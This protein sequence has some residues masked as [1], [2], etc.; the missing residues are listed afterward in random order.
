MLPGLWQRNTWPASVAISAK[1]K[2]SSPS[3]F[4]TCRRPQ[5][6]IYRSFFHSRICTCINCTLLFCLQ[7]V[8]GLCIVWVMGAWNNGITQCC[9]R[10]LYYDELH[11]NCVVNATELEYWHKFDYKPTELPVLGY[12]NMQ[13]L[14]HKII[15]SLFFIGVMYDIVV[16]QFFLE[17]CYLKCS[18]INV[19]HTSV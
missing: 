7:H 6:I 2:S 12:L 15:V 9:Q 11:I 1:L 16:T 10:L 19:Q 17:S 3:L 5:P 14:V 18:C 4:T 13:W 8:H